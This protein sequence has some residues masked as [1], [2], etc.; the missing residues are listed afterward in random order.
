MKALYLIGNG[1]RPEEYFY[2]K[3]E[4][5]K[6][7][8]KVITAG[9]QKVVPARDIP[10]MPKSTYVDITFDEVDLDKQNYNAVVVPGGSPG[11]ENLYKDN[12]VIE[13]LQKA[14]VKDLLIASLCASPAV[15]S[16]AGVL[17]GKKATIYPGMTNYLKKGGANPVNTDE[18]FEN[19]TVIV[20]DKNLVTG[21]GPWA[22]RDFGRAVVEE[23][24][25]SKK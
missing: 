1:F 20:K 15:L 25:K 6:A 4:I 7:G 14:Q 18:N 2:S 17:K 16:K 11:W 22:S 12:K 5:E 21:N 19:Q 8:I 24:T 3:E 23:L 13:I 9:K 10:G